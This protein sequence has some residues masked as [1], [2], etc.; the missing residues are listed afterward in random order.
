MLRR[1]LILL[2]CTALSAIGYAQ[3]NISSQFYEMQEAFNQAYS[4]PWHRI[5]SFEMSNAEG[6]ITSGTVDEKTYSRVESS[7]TVTGGINLTKVKHSS[8]VYVTGQDAPYLLKLALTMLTQLQMS[9]ST[10]SRLEPV[11][12]L[13]GAPD[14]SCFTAREPTEVFCRD[15][16]LPMI[17]VIRARNLFI[18]FNRIGKFR[19]Q[20][21]PLRIEM[22]VNGKVLMK[23][24]VEKLE[25]LDPSGASSVAVPPG[26]RPVSESL[27]LTFG[28]TRQQI[29]GAVPSYP[30]GAQSQQDSGDVLIA[31]HIDESGAVSALEPVSSPSLFLTKSAMTALSTW[32]FASVY[33]AGGPSDI[34]TLFTLQY[35][36][37]KAYKFK[38]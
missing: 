3:N 19:D 35:V 4:K 30:L 38:Q 36:I 32:K 8:A 24:N 7:L 28:I 20:Y 9:Y 31:A 17:R 26:A 21:V 2:F 13:K 22:A 10:P 15:K 1:L 6:E 37:P 33:E 16:K 23:M 5:V 27:M 18:M 34:D 14:F 29:K 25:E 12:P 11:S